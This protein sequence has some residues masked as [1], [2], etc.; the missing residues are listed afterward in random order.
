[1][2]S[3]L[4]ALLFLSVTALAAPKGQI[5]V[6]PSMLEA[7]ERS[8]LRNSLGAQDDRDFIVINGK[9]FFTGFHP[10]AEL[11]QGARFLTVRAE[12]DL[13]KNFDMRKFSHSPVRG[14]LQGS[15]W[16]EGNV[17]AFELTWNGILGTKMVFAVDDVIHCSGY[18]TARSGGQLSMEYNTK[19]GLAFESDYPYTA[20]DG[21]CRKDVERQHPLKEAPF[22]RGA[23]GDFPTE[24]ELMAAAYQYGAM[25][26]CG[27]ASA[28][29]SGGRQDTIRSGRTNHCYAYGGWIDGKEMGW[30]DSVY[31]LIKNS[32]GDC[33]NS[34]DLSNGRCW[35]DGG[36]GYYRLSKDGVTLSGSVIT[37]IQVADT[38]LPFRPVGPSEFEMRDVHGKIKVT[39][40]QGKLSARSVKAVLEKLKF[41]EVK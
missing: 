3:F 39:V 38:G 16:A 12:D 4:I 26:V 1:M 2:K 28:L 13:P 20:R 34:N 35:G 9:K 37:E 27:S 10:T 23:D 36:W 6:H 21:R 40:T 8:T 33:D 19:A 25:E 14:Q 18:G 5:Y 29:G 31:H 41:V 30:L 22:L 15:C 7:I 11:Y 24:R 32:W 17:S